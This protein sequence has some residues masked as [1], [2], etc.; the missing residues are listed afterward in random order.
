MR[1]QFIY[2]SAA[3]AVFAMASCGSNASEAGNA[4]STLSAG[5]SASDFK[6]SAESTLGWSGSKAVGIGQHAGTIAISEGTLSVENGNI[7]AG[8]FTIDMTKITVTDSGLPDDAKQK[9][10]GHFSSD[11]FFNVEKFPTSKFE[12]TEVK[13]EA[14]GANTHVIAGNLTLRDSVKNI[15]FPAAVSITADAVTAK[16]EVIINRLDWGVNYDKASMS[17]AETAQAKLKNGVVSKDIK[18][19]LDIKATK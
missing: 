13:A 14:N 3:V 2:L 12:I 5:D 8:T 4:D 18:I 15:S 6:V 17:L 1:K 11:D 7:T 19:T 10:V 9:L 16:G